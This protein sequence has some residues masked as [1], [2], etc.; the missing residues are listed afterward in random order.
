[1]APQAQKQR[2]FGKP[3]LNLLTEISKLWTFKSYPYQCGWK[4][5]DESLGTNCYELNWIELNWIARYKKDTSCRHLWWGFS[6]I[7][8]YLTSF[9]RKAM[10]SL[11]HAVFWLGR[12]ARPGWCQVQATQALDDHP[13]TENAAPLISDG[14]SANE[15]GLLH[16]LERAYRVAK[17]SNKHICLKINN[18]GRFGP[19]TG[20]AWRKTREPAE[21]PRWLSFLICEDGIL[22]QTHHRAQPKLRDLSPA[23]AM[24]F[25][26]R[27]LIRTCSKIYKSSILL[28]ACCWPSRFVISKA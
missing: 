12:S 19:Q 1:M 24:P 15:I 14:T 13:R 16:A 22:F 9:Q 17:R 8:C 7:Y 23:L 20:L 10:Y 11:R 27:Y 25:L 2:L 26:V 5:Q 6:P 21:S 3:Y 4:Q 18:F 28:G